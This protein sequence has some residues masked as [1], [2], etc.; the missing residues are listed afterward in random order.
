LAFIDLGRG[1]R[2]HN[3]VRIVEEKT[4]MSGQFWVGKKPQLWERNNK[5]GGWQWVW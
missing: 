3:G 5:N 1:R 4:K 2:I